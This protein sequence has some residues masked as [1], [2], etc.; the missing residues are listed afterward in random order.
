M[1]TN[2]KTTAL[3]CA[4]PMLMALLALAPNFAAAQTLDTVQI[5]GGDL[6]GGGAPLQGGI[7]GDGFSASLSGYPLVMYAGGQ[8]GSGGVFDFSMALSP[9]A[10]RDQGLYMSSINGPSASALVGLAPIVPNPLYPY[11]QETGGITTPLIDITGAGSYSAPFTLSAEVAYGVP[12]TTTPEG[13]VDIVGTGIVKIDIRPA[14]CD[15]GA[16][17]PLTFGD[18]D[19]KFGSSAPMMAP[20]IDPNSAASALTLLVGGILVLQSRRQSRGMRRRC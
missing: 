9:P 6:S 3:I 10:G 4:A 13:Y 12:G 15:S 1:D 5:T 2:S 20:E 19:F 16:C 11:F 18:V 8:L 7:T 14:N 17:G